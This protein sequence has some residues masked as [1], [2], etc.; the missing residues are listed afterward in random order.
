MFKK[1]KKKNRVL[2]SW[3]LGSANL[4]NNWAYHG[5]GPDFSYRT[6]RT[7]DHMLSFVSSPEKKKERQSGDGYSEAIFT[8]TTD[9]APAIAVQAWMVLSDFPWSSICCREAEP[10][11]HPSIGDG[12][13]FSSSSSGFYCLHMRT[14]CMY[15]VNSFLSV[16]SST[17]ITLFC[18][19]MVV[20]GNRPVV[21]TLLCRLMVI[22]SFYYCRKYS[23]LLL[24]ESDCVYWFSYSFLFSFQACMCSVL[25]DFQ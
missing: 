18:R 24:L 5:I 1:K 12:F 19:F 7:L 4:V 2:H 15:R 11:T 23:F 14:T 6:V 21:L 10:T 8:A 3:F 13:F 20:Y 22:F 9:G 16:N 17:S 25:T